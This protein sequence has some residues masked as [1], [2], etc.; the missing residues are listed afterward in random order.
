M[1]TGLSRRGFDID[2]SEGNEREDC[3][4]KVLKHGKVEL[5][6]DYRCMQTGNI[7]VEYAQNNS[8][9]RKPS[10]ILIKE[11]D[12]WA[13]ELSEG[14]YVLCDA[15]RLRKLVKQTIQESPWQCRRGGDNN[16]TEGVLLPLD[17]LLRK[18]GTV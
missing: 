11:S 7:Y 10:G 13:Y 1:T 18:L 14:L 12:W 4:A 17:G 16:G 9:G 8:T 2:L 15:K 3:L 5:K 6:T